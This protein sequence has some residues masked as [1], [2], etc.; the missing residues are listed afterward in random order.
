MVNY[1]T[2]IDVFYSKYLWCVS[3]VCRYQCGKNMECTL[4]NT[5][6]CKEGYT[7]Y[8]CHIGERERLFSLWVI[9]VM[10]HHY[11]AF[12]ANLFCAQL[13][14]LPLEPQA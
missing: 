9:T 4:P 6:T 1:N 11:K 10:A 14:S 3:A 13:R 8:N 12:L 2:I 7:G 5:C